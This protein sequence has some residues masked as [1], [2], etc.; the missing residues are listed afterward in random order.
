[1]RAAKPPEIVAEAQGAKQ[2]SVAQATGE[3][4]R[5]DAVL[6]AYEAAKDVTLKRM[7][8][9]TMRD[10]LTHAQTLVVDDKL[11][12]LVPFLPLNASGPEWRRPRPAAYAT[13]SRRPRRIA[14]AVARSNLPRSSCSRRETG[15]EPDPD[16]GDRRSRSCC[17]CWSMPACSP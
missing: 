12:G 11:K 9:D 7:Y 3:S 6:K 4:Q 16:R 13:P 2:A 15:N 10:I 5:F 8:V 14:D 17:W 1:M